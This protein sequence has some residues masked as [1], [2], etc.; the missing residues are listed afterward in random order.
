MDQTT[1][2]GSAAPHGAF[3]SSDLES[4]TPA[5]SARS[6]QPRLGHASHRSAT[7]GLSRASEMRFPE[8]ST[9]ILHGQAWSPTPCLSFPHAPAWSLALPQH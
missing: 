3:S 4:P 5:I 8:P 6:V 1:S 7:M 9:S 2:L